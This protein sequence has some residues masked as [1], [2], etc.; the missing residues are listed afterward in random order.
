[1]RTGGSGPTTKA[2]KALRALDYISS[3]GY[4]LK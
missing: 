4:M 3:A 1:M 2:K